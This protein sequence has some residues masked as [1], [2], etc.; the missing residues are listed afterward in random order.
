M[1]VTDHT[2]ADALADGRMTEDD[3]EHV[4]AFERY[5][6]LAPPPALPAADGK[7]YYTRDELAQWRYALLA[8]YGYDPPVDH[9]EVLAL[10][11][12]LLCAP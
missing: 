7:R 8:A 11:D 12:H 1:I 4:R 2:V 3:A 10:I 6:R 9:A 5:L